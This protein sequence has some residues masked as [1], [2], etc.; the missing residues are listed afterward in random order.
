MKLIKDIIIQTIEAAEKVGVDA[1]LAVMFVFAE[2]LANEM[3]MA[4]I[5]KSGKEKTFEFLKEFARIT[6]NPLSEEQA[7]IYAER[8]SE[9]TREYEALTKKIREPEQAG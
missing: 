3:T 8:L 9:L 4:V 5:V 6:G 2:S 1:N 7:K